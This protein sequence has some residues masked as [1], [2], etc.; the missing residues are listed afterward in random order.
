MRRRMFA[1]GH[2]EADG[3]DVRPTLL[4]V[5]TLLFLLLFFLLGTTSGE[6]LAVIGLRVGASTGLAPLPHAGLLKSLRVEVPGDGSVTLRATVQTTDISASATTTEDRVVVVSPRAGALDGP[7]LDKAL[8][9][10]HAVDATQQRATVLPGDGVPTQALMTV[11]DAVR[12]PQNSRFPEVVLQD[13]ADAPPTSA[14]PGV[15]P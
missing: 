3:A 7:A 5:V 10:L 15:G 13:L 2:V 12:G 6:K 9:D 4:G 1:S 11:L 8:A 14:A